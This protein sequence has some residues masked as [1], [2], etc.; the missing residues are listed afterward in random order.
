MNIELFRIELTKLV[1]QCGGQLTG[2]IDIVI[3]GREKR[4]AFIPSNRKHYG[5]SQID[6]VR[7]VRPVQLSFSI[8]TAVVGRWRHASGDDRILHPDLKKTTGY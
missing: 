8:Q 5:N 3:A 4:E 6:A 1:E 2:P 7:A